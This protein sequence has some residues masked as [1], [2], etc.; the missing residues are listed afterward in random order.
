[1]SKS[2]KARHGMRCKH[3]K[4][5]LQASANQK[6]AWRKRKQIEHQRARARAKADL[7]LEAS[8]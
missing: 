6:R 8:T 1:M 3:W 4:D 2:H 5:S 7:F